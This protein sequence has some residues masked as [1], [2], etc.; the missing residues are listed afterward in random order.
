MPFFVFSGLRL[1]S[2]SP[3]QALVV[4]LRRARAGGDPPATTRQTRCQTLPSKEEGNQTPRLT[5]LSLPQRPCY[6]RR[7]PARYLLQLKHLTDGLPTPSPS[8]SPTCSPHVLI[9]IFHCQIHRA[10]YFAF[11]HTQADLHTPTCILAQT[12]F[13]KGEQQKLLLLTDLSVLVREQ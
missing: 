4:P 3:S 6:H 11:T 8:F 10:A 7:A 12:K 9:S 13:A 2:I 1:E 5:R